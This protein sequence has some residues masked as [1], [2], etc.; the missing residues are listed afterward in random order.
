MKSARRSMFVMPFAFVAMLIALFA[1]THNARATAPA[2]ATLGSPATLSVTLLP[3]TATAA[4]TQT[5]VVD[6]LDDIDHG[7]C[8]PTI[9]TLRDAIRT[10]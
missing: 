3:V 9:C 1:A 2:T 8:R 4:P 7:A 6:N 5:L 10:A